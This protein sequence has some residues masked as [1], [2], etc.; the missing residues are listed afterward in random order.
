MVTYKNKIIIIFVVV[1][2]FSSCTILRFMDLAIKPW[3]FTFKYEGKNTKLDS[4]CSINGIYHGYYISEPYTTYSL[5]GTPY[6]HESYTSNFDFVFYNDGLAFKSSYGSLGFKKHFEEI[7]AG[8][9][10]MDTSFYAYGNGIACGSYILRN[11]TIKLQIIYYDGPT[12][13]PF[14]YEY[15]FKIIDKRNILCFMK[16]CR[17]CDNGGDKEIK[18]NIPL[19]FEEYDVPKLHCWLKE[20]YWFYK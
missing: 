3:E 11:D 4:L 7:K 1:L 6:Y 5:D 16:C 19:S 17:T 9:T 10:R 18:C 13:K 8:I 2:L 15:W 14:V 12:S 20:W